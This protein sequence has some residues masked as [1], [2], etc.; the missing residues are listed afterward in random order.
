MAWWGRLVMGGGL[1]RGG[2]GGGGLLG[3]VVVDFAVARGAFLGGGAREVR[4]QLEQDGYVMS[5][6]MRKIGLR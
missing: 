4:F 1:G 5:W 2:V 3:I 6:V